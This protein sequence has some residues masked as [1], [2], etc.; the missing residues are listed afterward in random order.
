MALQATARRRMGRLKEARLERLARA[1][2]LEAPLVT[3]M[4]GKRKYDE[5][6][7]VEANDSLDAGLELQKIAI[8]SG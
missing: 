6:P 8:T 2:S 3:Y 1:M 5:D 4:E 7:E